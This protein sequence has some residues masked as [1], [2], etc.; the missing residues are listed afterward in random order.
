MA[1]MKIHHMSRMCPK[2]CLVVTLEWVSCDCRASE[3]DIMNLLK[4]KRHKKVT[5]ASAQKLGL[6]DPN[7]VTHTARSAI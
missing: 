1:R 6:F 3:L 5:L 2:L 7:A 4:D